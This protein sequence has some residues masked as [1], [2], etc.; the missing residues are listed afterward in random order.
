MKGLDPKYRDFPE[1]IL[2]VTQEIWK[3]RGIDTLQQTYAPDIIV[4]SPASV[5][6]V[7]Q[8]VIAATLATLAEF[9]DRQVFGEDVIWCGTPETGLLSS[10]R[11]HSTQTHAREGIY[12]APSGRRLHYRIIADC[13]ARA[14]QIDDEWLI[15]DQGTIVR[16]LGLDPRD[17]ARDLIAREGGAAACPPPLTPETEIAA[18]AQV[19][20]P[21]PPCVSA[22]EDSW[23]QAIDLFVVRRANVLERKPLS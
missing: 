18:A 15:R 5:V 16:Q 8:G 10:H 3:G 7:N 9:P 11:L 4:R 23:L 14:N 2:G 1:F 21:E 13:H 17:S 19:V 12:G 22:A 20:T 6:R